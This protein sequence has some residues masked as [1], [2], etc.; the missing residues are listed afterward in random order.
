MTLVLDG[1]A[2]LAWCFADERTPPLMA[3]LDRVGEAG[4][5]APTLWPLEVTNGLLM[6]QRRK[7]L[8]ADE[9]DAMIGFLRDLPVALDHASAAQAWGATALLAERHRLTLYDATY[10]E[11]ALRRDLPLATLDTALRKAA[12]QAGVTVLPAEE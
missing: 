8:S 7:R 4:A 5:E 9:R 3:L 12:V 1:S 10:L 6:A 11:L 2:A